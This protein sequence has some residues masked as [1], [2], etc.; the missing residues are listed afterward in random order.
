MWKKRLQSISG[1]LKFTIILAAIGIVYVLSTR[2]EQNLSSLIC[3]ASDLGD[4]FVLAPSLAQVT[5]PE[6]EEEVKDYYAVFLIDPSLTNTILD[7]T[8]IKY[9]SEAAAHR[10][11][12]E[13]CSIPSHFPNEELRVGE[14][15]CYQS[16]CPYSLIFRRDEFLVQMCGDYM[17]LEPV[18]NKVDRRIEESGFWT[19]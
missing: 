7:C 16:R 18:A 11:L 3:Q 15:A 17:P 1:S 12:E 4:R 10:A 6:L 5:S 9:E 2:Q 13:L 8:I 19:H 14:E